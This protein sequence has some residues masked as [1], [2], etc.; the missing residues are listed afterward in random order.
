M[1]ETLATLL[2]TSTLAVIT[3]MFWPECTLLWA[4]P[5]AVMLGIVAASKK[6]GKR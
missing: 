6:S 2:T 3:A 5:A 1:K 4:I